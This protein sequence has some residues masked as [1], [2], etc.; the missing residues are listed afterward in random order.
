MLAKA[1][2]VGEAIDGYPHI[3]AADVGMGAFIRRLRWSDEIVQDWDEI[4]VSCEKASINKTRALT[5]LTYLYSPFTSVGMM[6]HGNSYW[7]K[8]WIP[9][10]RCQQPQAGRRR[11]R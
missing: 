10:S 7:R 6:V 3:L 9:C 11:E 4:L 8:I 5:P 2:D 1:E